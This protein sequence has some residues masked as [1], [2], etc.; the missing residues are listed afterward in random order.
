MSDDLPDV[1]GVMEAADHL[2]QVTHYKNEDKA[3]DPAT[4]YRAAHTAVE[5]AA[6]KA[7]LD[8]VIAEHA[9]WHDCI[10]DG[11]C[12]RFV[13]LQQQRQALEGAETPR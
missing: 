3:D 5:R 9:H 1:R 8:A 10:D 2:V 12:E 13:N 4:E 11:F 6:K 7:V